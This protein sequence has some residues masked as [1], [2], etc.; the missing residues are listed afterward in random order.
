MADSIIERLLSLFGIKKEEIARGKKETL[1]EVSPA[2]EQSDK[3]KAVAKR[4]RY[5]RRINKKL[6]KQLDSWKRKVNKLNKKI[7]E[8]EKAIQDKRIEPQKAN[9]I[10]QV[11]YREINDESKNITSELENVS[12]LMKN[13]EK[14]YLKRHI[15]DSEFRQK[16]LEYKEREYLLQLKKKELEKQKNSTNKISNFIQGALLITNQ[17]PTVVYDSNSIGPTKVTQSV[18]VSLVTDVGKFKSSAQQTTS[19]NL[20]NKYDKKLIDKILEEKAKG[21]IDENKLKELEQ[22]LE[23]LV[24]QKNIPPNEIEKEL[25]SLDTKSFVESFNKLVSLLEIEHKAKE[26]YSKPSYREIEK[27]GPIHEKE[28]I[29]GIIVELQ[30]HRIITDLDKIVSYLSEKKKASTGEISKVLN[31]DKKK[32]LD[33][34]EILEDE[35]VV[36]INYLPIGDPLLIIKD[37]SERT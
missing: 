10:I 22:K 25:N 35:G 26:I 19:E 5:R 29:K 28:K 2:C 37:R 20:E 11:V 36:I 3:Q 34:A 21:K 7:K 16:M 13:L 9:E 8:L 17:N 31:I 12:S 18:P 32:V 30:K 15:T 14:E 24:K 4:R 1:E 6:L 27:Y 23:F 33:Y